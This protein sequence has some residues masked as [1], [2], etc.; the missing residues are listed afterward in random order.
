MGCTDALTVLDLALEARG[1]VRVL[2]AGL[3]DPGTARRAVGGTTRGPAVRLAEA[4]AM[5]DLALQP[6]STVGVHRALARRTRRR[7]VVAGAA[8]S[9]GVSARA[10]RVGLRA[11]RVIRAPR[12]PT[13]PCGLH[14]PA[15]CSTSHSRPALQSVSTTQRSPMPWG[16][17]PG[18]GSPPQAP[19]AST[20][21][22]ASR[23][24]MLERVSWERVL[25]LVFIIVVLLRL[26]RVLATTKE[27][28]GYRSRQRQGRPVTG[29]GAFREKRRPREEPAPRDVQ[30]RR[31]AAAPVQG[32]DG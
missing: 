28:V 7:G 1:A 14:E 6:R 11:G 19:S 2:A 18:S 10:A 21:Q 31:R 9:T 5:L 25:S 23:Q 13:P 20:P 15:P 3:P 29:A 32:H 24:R 8:F 26:G 22:Q 4:H 27:V 12:I 16:N 30:R 17:C